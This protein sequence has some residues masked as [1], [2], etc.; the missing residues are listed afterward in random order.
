MQ[1]FRVGG[2]PEHFNWP[3]HLALADQAFD[4]PS[5]QLRFRDYPGGTGAMIEDLGNRKLDLALLLTEGALAGALNGANY[6][7]VKVFV[8]SP[9]TWGIH[10]AAHSDLSSMRDSAGRRIA[11]SRYGSGSHLIAIVD[12]LA[13]GLPID[14]LK[15]V[16]V[17]DLA[18]ARRALAADEADIFLW[19]RFTTNPLVVSGEFRRIDQCIVPW[20][21]FTVA[22]RDD[23][24]PEH[25]TRIRYMLETVHRYANRLKRRKYAAQEIA[26]Q[27]DLRH[28]D[29]KQWFRD[30]RWSASFR[31]P[32]RALRVCSA[33]LAQCGIL[34]DDVGDPES[35]W[36]H[37]QS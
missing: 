14:N 20:P 5:T 12:A 30:V 2:V 6:K 32:Q 15:F 11:I 3:W 29:A 36:H 7:M 31:M 37:L 27:Y 34:T 25:E 21:A 17:G 8:S 35:V 1:K 24:L 26:D 28:A 23:L 9:L 18:G 10:V 33:A 16:V 13:R 22:V 19:E 4:G